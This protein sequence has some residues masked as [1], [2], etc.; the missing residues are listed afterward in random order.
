M[1]KKVQLEI[2]ILIVNYRGK[3]PPYLFK[4]SFYEDDAKILAVL[5]DKILFTETSL[6]SNQN[7]SQAFYGLP[8][9]LSI[10]S[11]KID[12]RNFLISLNL[13]EPLGLD[14][15]WNKWHHV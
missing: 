7:I 12:L 15:E 2:V 8:V 6:F 3:N 9:N 1:L 5:F 10:L 4:W 14:M 11:W 13:L